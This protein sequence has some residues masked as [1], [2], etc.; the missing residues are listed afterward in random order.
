MLIFWIGSFCSH[1]N[2]SLIGS[3][4]IG[5]NIRKKGSKEEEFSWK[6]LTFSKLKCWSKSSLFLSFWILY[7]W[8]CWVSLAAPAFLR[9]RR[10]RPALHRCA[11][12]P[13]AAFC[14]AEQGLQGA[15]L[16]QLWL[17]ALQHR[18]SSCGSRA[19]HLPRSGTEPASPSMAGR[20]LT[21][22]PSGKPSLFYSTFWAVFAESQLSV[23]KSCHQIFCDPIDC[24]PPGS[25]VHGIS[26]A[27]VLEWVAI[28]FSRGFSQPRDGTL[29]SCIA[30]R[31][32]II[33]ATGEAPNFYT[34]QLFWHIIHMKPYLRIRYGGQIHC[35]F[36]AAQ[37]SICLCLF[38]KTD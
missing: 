9:L 32:S 12:S 11:A 38:S 17:L 14:A 23:A 4:V 33:W 35:L 25:S 7:F 29:I 37:F 1:L 26:Q 34:D 6:V 3:C 2:D 18:L 30:D 22:E 13:V 19:V 10:A 27:R 21:T 8:L 16:K 28:P 31:F 5:K 15:D 20:C 36:K 24:S